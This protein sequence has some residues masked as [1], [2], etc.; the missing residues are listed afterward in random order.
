MYDLPSGLI[1]AVLMISMIAAMYGGLSV[2]RVARKKRDEEAKS[3]TLTVQGSLLG[4]LGLLLGFTFSVSLSRY[5]MRSQAVVDEAN[6]I[7]TAWLRTDLLA[8][9]PRAEARALLHRYAIVRSEAGRVPASE[10]DRRLILVNA[11]EEIFE[12]LWV[13]AAQEARSERGPVALAFVTSL[14]DMSD[15]LLSRN[16]AI[17][18]HVPEVVLFTL[19]GTFIVVG[20]VLGL[21]SAQGGLRPGPPVY[22]M[23]ALIVVLVFLIIDLDRPRRG[24]IEV[25]QSPLLT[26]AAEMEP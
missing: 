11:A 12:K 13:L 24:L 14:N 20:A 18:R 6:A 19:Y 8:D 10:E 4:I 17:E 25:D 1:A 16:A 23:I 22:A 15:A 5:D 2:G 7:G 26:L 3:Q 9:E 21:G